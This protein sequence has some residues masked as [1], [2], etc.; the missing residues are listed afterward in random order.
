MALNCCESDRDQDTAQSVIEAHLI[1]MFGAVIDCMWWPWQRV[2]VIQHLI[3]A[4]FEEGLLPYYE[5]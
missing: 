3:Q 4:K 2:V 5:F 1:N